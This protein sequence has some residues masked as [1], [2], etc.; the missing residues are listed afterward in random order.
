MKCCGLG[1]KEKAGELEDGTHVIRCTSC[2]VCWIKATK[3]KRVKAH[4]K[5]FRKWVADTL[6]DWAHTWDTEYPENSDEDIANNKE[7]A[8]CYE[9]VMGLAKRF[10]KGEETNKDK[11][12]IIFHLWQSLGQEDDE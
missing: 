2:G 12:E 1:Q 10:R 11:D 5:E 8:E 4:E 6:E 3:G 9:Y 7:N